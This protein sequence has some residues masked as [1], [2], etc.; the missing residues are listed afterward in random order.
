M[1]S[2]EGPPP[3][4]WLVG[5][6]NKRPIAWRY[7]VRDT[8]IGLLNSTVH[9]ALRLLPTELCSGFGALLGPLSR[10]R[11]PESDAR[12]RRL[13]TALHP[14][15][16][17]PASLDRVMRHLWRCVGR[18]MAEFS[19]LDRFWSEGRIVVEGAEH[20]TAARATGKPILVASCHL[21]NWETIG[22]TLVPL[23]FPGSGFYEPPEN[24]FDHRIAVKVRLR[25]GAKLVFPTRIG[26]REAYRLLTEI[27]DEVFLIYVDELFRGRVSA[28]AFGRALKPEGNIAHVARLARLTGAAVI[29]VYCVRLNDRARFKVTYLPPINLVRSESKLG[30]LEANIAEIDRTFAPVIKAHLDQWYYALDFEPDPPA[31]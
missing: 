23:G 20:L 10:Y 5:D 7:W 15:E 31:P 28:P 24:R 30:D 6:G 3:L 17:D 19:V 11:Y 22:T 2:A 26:G 8:A 16:S 21:G 9:A 13:W 14:Q 25:Y 27:K 18:T 12:A 1:V 4:L 29:P